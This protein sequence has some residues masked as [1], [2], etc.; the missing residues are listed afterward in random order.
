MNKSEMAMI[1]SWNPCC[2]GLEWAK[3]QKN[4]KQ[5][6]ENCPNGGWLIFILNSIGKLTNKRKGIL[7][8][9]LVER[10][11]FVWDKY[12]PNKKEPHVALL[13]KA[14]WLTNPCPETACVLKKTSIDLNKVIKSFINKNAYFVA[15]AVS[16]V[17]SDVEPDYRDFTHA[18]ILSKLAI[19]EENNK[20]HHDIEELEQA[21]IIRSY[22]PNPFR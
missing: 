4:L 2:D 12:Y 9:A 21:K 7:G 11:L 14:S 3:K 10:A 16:L 18:L 15:K 20:F 22:I 8:I 1:K 5:L 19:S 17:S 6:W 13:A